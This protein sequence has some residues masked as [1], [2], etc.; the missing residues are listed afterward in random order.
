M[1]IAGVSLDGHGLV[2]RSL[3]SCFYGTA[4]IT[5]VLHQTE[6]AF[7][8]HLEVR[9]P[10]SNTCGGRQSFPTPVP[11]RYADQMSRIGAQRQIAWSAGESAVGAILDVT[12]ASGIHDHVR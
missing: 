4:I 10:R 12:N 6:I 2:R 1:V 5:H 11:L 3:N 8:A 9:D 7:T